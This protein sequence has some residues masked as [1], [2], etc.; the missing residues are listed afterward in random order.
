MEK[1]RAHFNKKFN[2]IRPKTP[3][4]N[5]KPKSFKTSKP[6]NTNNIQQQRESPK[7]IDYNKLMEKYGNMI[8]NSFDKSSHSNNNQKKKYIY[9]I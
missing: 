7:T 1:Q 4:L 2:K 9:K 8:D 3:L 6:K 5:K